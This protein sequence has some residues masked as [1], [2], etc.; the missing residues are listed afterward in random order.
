MLSQPSRSVDISPRSTPHSPFR[1]P[2]C[3]RFIDGTAINKI[4]KYTTNRSPKKINSA[5]E[6]K[7]RTQEIRPAFNNK[8]KKILFMSDLAKIE[9][10]SILEELF[11]NLSQHILT[12]EIMKKAPQF[13]SEFSLTCCSTYLSQVLIIHEETDFIGN[14]FGD[15]I[16]TE[17]ERIVADNWARKNVRVIS[18]SINKVKNQNV[19]ASIYTNFG[20]ASD[21]RRTSILKHKEERKNSKNSIN[22][23]IT[24]ARKSRLN[25]TAT[26]KEKMDKTVPEPVN[27]EELDY[28]D[29]EFIESTKKN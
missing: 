18:K 5:S 9:V 27:I 21:K 26:I 6:W 29:E 10:N 12:K 15:N 1:I 7:I 23:N 17:P 14:T 3:S 11:E 20:K 16:D 22:S 28:I 2:N 24:F 19:E 13:L 4:S 25:P 8:A